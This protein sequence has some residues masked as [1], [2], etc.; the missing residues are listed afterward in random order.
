MPEVGRF[1]NRDVFP[2]FAENPLS[3]HKYAY[4]ENNPVGVSQPLSY[5]LDKFSRMALFFLGI[6]HRFFYII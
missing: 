5:F 1:V 3:M 4:V 6:R 2:G